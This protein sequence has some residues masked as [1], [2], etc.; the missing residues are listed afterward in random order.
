M[1]DHDH[2][3]QSTYDGISAPSAEASNSNSTSVDNW[4]SAC[5]KLLDEA[6]ENNWPATE[7]ADALKRL[8]LKAAEAIDYIEELS[9]RLEI[10]RA[11]ARDP[12]LPRQE[13]ITEGNNHVTEQAERDRE[14][15]EAAWAS[16]RS[17]LEDANTVAASASSSALEKVLELLG[18]ES[19]PSSSLSKS[20]LAVAPHLA[21]NDDSVFKDPYLSKTQ[22]CKIAYASQK[23]FKNLIIKAQGRKMQEPVAYS[24]WKLVILDKYVNFEKL[25]ATLDPDYN[26]NDEAKDLNDNFTLLEKNSVS[27][28]RPVLT[29]AE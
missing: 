27:S 22:D 3:S 4:V 25:Y 23:P 20:V 8:G 10:R 6:V 28:K 15:E 13:P 16:L 2:Q 12:G 1:P 17:K 18:Q 5:E 14:V 29:E 19:S 24:I 11:K 26:P 21:D 9:Q 7:L